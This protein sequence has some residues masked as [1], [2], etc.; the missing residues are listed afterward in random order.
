MTR[1]GF[2]KE[3]LARQHEVLARHVE[4]GGTPGLVAAVARGDEVHVDAIGA[5]EPDGGRPVGADT[6]FRI[7]SMTK[8]VVAVAAMVLVEDCRLRLDE[9][10]DDHL[11]ELADRRVLVDADGPL[12]H[13]VPADR[14]ITTRDLLT[15]SS[16]YGQPFT[17]APGAPYAR[18]M[19]DP[20]ICTGPP[21]PGGNV[22]P[23]EWLRR[24]GE[25]PLVHQPGAGWR[26]HVSADLLG[27]LLARAADQPLEEVLRERVFEPLGMADTAFSAAAG[28]DRF[29]AAYDL[30]PDGDGLVV[31]D[32]VDGEW[33]KPPA[34]PSAAGGLVSTASDY[35]A[36]ARMLRAGGRLDSGERLLSRPSVELLTSDQLSD[37]QKA[38]ADFVLG[39]PAA[40]SWGFGVG[41]V[42]RR[43][44]HASVGTYGWSGGLGSLWA[45][46]PVEDLTCVLLTNRV[47]MSPVA[48]TV[49]ADFL[50]TSYAAI[51]G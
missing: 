26:Y 44:D 49:A 13:T 42:T 34:F 37:A 2:S 30:S 12:D 24:M 33:S 41:V 14:S 9:P 48:P 4:A 46:D 27:M 17:V 38:D 39:D 11:P 32:P 6:L 23:D 8:P 18:A 45:N 16:G 36:F 20:A 40:H 22:A 35:L 28:L 31:W 15:F 29:G 5:L 21:A 7:S 47:W 1:N 19:E 51:D 3:G 43:T 25:I 10:V 50:T